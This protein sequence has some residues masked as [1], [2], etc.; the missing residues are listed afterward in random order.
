MRL[1]RTWALLLGLVAL[2][3]RAELPPER[4][5][6][7]LA[8]ILSYD[9]AQPDR[10]RDGLVAV[11]LHASDEAAAAAAMATALGVMNVNR[12]SI[13]AQAA[14]FSSL[15][16]LA[17]TLSERKVDFIYVT[18]LLEAHVAE[19]SELA[20]KLKVP[21]L[22]GKRSHLDLGCAVAIT[23]AANQPHLAVHLE[24][25]KRQGMKLSATVLSLAEVIR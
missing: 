12:V 5:A 19:I 8:R 6:A 9:R 23:E 16:E 15:A 10:A 11:V 21:V 3:A 25:S 18:P 14:P 1:A 7:I 22:S 4:Q 24:R 13:S 20:E 2:P 17:V